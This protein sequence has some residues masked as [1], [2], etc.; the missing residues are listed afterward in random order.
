MGIALSIHP[1][2]MDPKAKHGTAASTNSS[3]NVTFYNRWLVL[4]FCG[5]L[6][7]Q[8]IIIWSV[9]MIFLNRD[10]QEQSLRSPIT[11]I[12]SGTTELKA[13]PS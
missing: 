4:S 6:K 8:L 10:A 1:A 7:S 5:M 12:I 2:G 11:S 9:G 13:A 3:L